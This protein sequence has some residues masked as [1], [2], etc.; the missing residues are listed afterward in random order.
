ME[1][2]RK[3]EVYV[4]EILK[5]R[6]GKIQG[7]TWQKTRNMTGGKRTKMEEREKRKLEVKCENMER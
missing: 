3:Q 5:G 1:E 6:K 2:L 7:E 4:T